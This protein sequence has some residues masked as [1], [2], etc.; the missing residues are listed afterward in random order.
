MCD[1]DIYNRL[2]AVRRVSERIEELETL[3]ASKIAR[4]LPSGIAYD[5]VKV[6]TSPDDPMLS[7][8]E[9]LDELERT[10]AEMR[11]IDMPKAIDSVMTVINKLKHSTS[12]QVFVRIFIGLERV[13]K[14]AEEMCYTEDGIYRIRRRGLQ[15]LQ[16][17]KVSSGF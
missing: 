16:R 1:A 14:I 2:N 5:G 13:P 6:Q 3:R 17:L 9:E 7:T 10:I 4:L 12:R 11:R 15:E 8:F